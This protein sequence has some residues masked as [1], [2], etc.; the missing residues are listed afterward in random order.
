MTLAPLSSP[1]RRVRAA[2]DASPLLAAV[3]GN[4]RALRRQQG[5]GNSV[6]D[7]ALFK[8][9]WFDGLVAFFIRRAGLVPC[10]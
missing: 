7:Q 8:P 2:F 3:S 9:L 4:A 10:G 6:F 5:D 1:A